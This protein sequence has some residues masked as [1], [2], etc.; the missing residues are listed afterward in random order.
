MAETPSMLRQ[1]HQSG[2]C[3]GRGLK[4]EETQIWHWLFVIPRVLYELKHH[5]ELYC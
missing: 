3:Q 5:G 4:Y 1:V 2:G